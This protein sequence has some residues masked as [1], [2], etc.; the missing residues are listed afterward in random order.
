MKVRIQLTCWYDA[1]DPCAVI[2]PEDIII[3]DERDVRGQIITQNHI[4]DDVSF[5]TKVK[6]HKV[7]F[8]PDD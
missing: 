3:T 2:W 6:H 5:L 7:T 1:S 4:L 8:F